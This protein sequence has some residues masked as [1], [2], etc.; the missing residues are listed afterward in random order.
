MIKWFNE[1]KGA[2]FNFIGYLTFA[3][4]LV[5]VFIYLTFPWK[6]L[7]RFIEFQVEEALD[8][9]IEVQKSEFHFPL[10]LVWTGVAFRP[11]EGPKSVHVDLDNIS[12]E[13]T[14]RRFLQR[15]LELLWSVKLAGGEGNGQIAAQPT[16]RGMQYRFEGDLQD[17]HL[18]NLITFVAPNPYG[19]DG[20]IG[21]TH[22]RHDWVGENIF[23]GT[24]SADL[25]VTDARSKTFDIGFNRIT[26]HLVM[27]G[28]VAQLDDFLAQGPAMDL[29]GSGN[30]LFRPKLEDSLVNFNSR[31]TIRDTKGPLALLGA[32]SP[33]RGA[34]GATEFSLRGTF[35]R[36]TIFMN[37]TPVNFPSTS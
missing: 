8:S 24:G 19:L 30:V 5:T 10:K 2:L 32:L 4:I 29:T 15:R 36:P 14:L 28:G 20:V 17:I 16:D 13:W 18:E 7:S 37:G 23:R 9:S 33:K 11:R 3:V 6:K 22:A 27:K 31:A 12:L 26:G 35:R 21:I 1:H 25:E 34:G